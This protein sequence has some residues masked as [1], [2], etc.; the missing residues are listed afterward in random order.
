MGVGGFFRLWR[1]IHVVR[2]GVSALCYIII[3]III[4]III[5]Y[6]KTQ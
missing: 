3:I 6:R 5:A 1:S 4:I 2:D